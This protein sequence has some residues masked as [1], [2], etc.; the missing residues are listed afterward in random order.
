MG[1][2][3]EK[4][5]YCLKA[6]EIRAQSLLKMERFDKASFDFEKL[7]ALQND[8]RDT[9]LLL[10]RIYYG[11]GDEERGL[12]HLQRC[13]HSDQEYKPCKTIYS[14]MKLL[15][16]SFKSLNEKTSS[17]ILKEKASF[18]ETARKSDAIF[19]E[20][21][22]KL[23]D[24]FTF[25]DNE[26]IKFYCCA[27]LKERKGKEAVDY[28]KKASVI[29]EENE[30]FIVKLAEAYQLEKDF[31][32]AVK[33]LEEAIK[34]NEHSEVLHGAL[35]SAKQKLAKS[36]QVDYYEVLGVDKQ[37]SKAEIKKQYKRMA[38][39][40]HPDKNPDN[41]EESSK[42]MVQLNHAYEILMDD[43]KR[44]MFD[45]GID[46]NDPHGGAGGNPF[47]GDFFDMFRQQQQNQHF[48]QSQGGGGGQWEQFFGGG[49]RQR[50]GGNNWG[51][52]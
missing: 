1:I 42:K 7:A 2:V 4:S 13:L 6:L 47:G 27:Y 9:H 23:A 12:A 40:Y 52:F 3:I 48:R 16:N 14:K 49:G 25:F 41:A 34:K 30:S 20:K 10:A 44:R 21:S 8:S 51:G 11:R 29:F 43:E 39:K 5:P 33:I 24:L 37:A 35:K 38:A 46:P 15:K 26:L 17:S 45:A 22:Y 28:C 36:Q 32:T 31:E 50:K 19:T 18:L